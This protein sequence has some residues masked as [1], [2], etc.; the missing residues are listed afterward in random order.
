[1]SSEPSASSER[2]KPLTFRFADYKRKLGR[3]Y[4]TIRLNRLLPKLEKD[5]Q[6]HYASDK[7]ISVTLTPAEKY[8]LVFPYLS[9]RFLEQLKAIV[10]LALYLILF[11]IIILNQLSSDYVRDEAFINVPIWRSN[12]VRSQCYVMRRIVALRNL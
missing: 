5:A 2:S 8:R 3:A 9:E 12:V 6:G 11:Q 7:R 1:M 4:E 10:P